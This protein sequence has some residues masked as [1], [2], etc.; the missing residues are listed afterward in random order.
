MEHYFYTM[1]LKTVFAIL[2]IVLYTSC[3]KSSSPG[4]GGGGGGG[5]AVDC[6]VVAKSFSTNVQPITSSRCAIPGCHAAG[7]TNGPG[8]LTTYQQI[9]NARAQ[10]RPAVSS[11]L[12]PQG[13]TL[14]QA[15]I[16]TIVC[17]IDSGAPNN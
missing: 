8:E 2:F 7:S 4:G 1:K 14:T 17:W 5:G 13:S 12:M 11:G 10:I 6:S 16:N 9:F 3:S 15:Q